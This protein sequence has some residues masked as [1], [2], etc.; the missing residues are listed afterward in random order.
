MLPKTNCRFH[1]RDRVMTSLNLL[2]FLRDFVPEYHYTK[3][4]GDWTTNEGKLRKEPM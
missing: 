3:V 1:T 4:G 2:M